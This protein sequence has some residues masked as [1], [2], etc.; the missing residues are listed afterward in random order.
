MWK[1]TLLLTICLM[2]VVTYYVNAFNPDKIKCCQCRSMMPDRFDVDPQILPSPF[3]IK[4]APNIR[5]YTPG[6]DINGK[7][8]S[9]HI[10]LLSK[11]SSN[12]SHNQGN[13]FTGPR[14]S[15]SSRWSFYFCKGFLLTLVN[16][17]YLQ[18][19]E[20]WSNLLKILP[21]FCWAVFFVRDT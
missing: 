15:C 19:N 9:F 4:V 8:N 21:P 17:N 2:A 3:V 11:P 14:H 18:M 7:F 1:S 10:S 16:G 6:L 12:L 20:I 13:F 5:R